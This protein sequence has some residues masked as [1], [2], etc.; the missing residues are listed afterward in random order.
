M[1]AHIGW[2]GVVSHPPSRLLFVIKSLGI[3]GG[4]AE[5]VLSDIV[6]ELA[7]RGHEVT[8][9]SFDPAEGT[10]FYAIGSKVRRLR[11]AV[12]DVRASSGPLDFLRK[13][14]ALRR[15]VRAQE[16]DAAVGFM[17]SAY[18]PLGLAALGTRTR[19][20]A[21]EHTPIDHFGSRPL[22]KLLIRSTASFYSA[23]TAPTDA[24][25]RAYPPGIARK[26]TVI[27]N[28]VTFAPASSGERAP[29]RRRLLTV[30]G[31]RPEK[32]HR[33]LIAA[34][35][36]IANS[37]PEWVLRIVGD[38]PC[39][40]ALERQVSELRLDDRIVFTGAVADVGREYGAADLFVIPSVYESFGLA[41]AEALASGLPVVGFADCP[42]TNILIKHEL[43]GLLV[44][45]EDRVASL[46]GALERLMSSSEQ[47]EAL[48]RAGPASVEQYSLRAVV[49]RWEALLKSVLAT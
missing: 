33:T 27:A 11:L 32:G 41:T 26:I 45:S 13:I 38:G 44:E 34:F 49:D 25:A 6:S 20:I 35:A 48:G 39:R 23:Y 2:R 36:R 17:H 22:Q 19:I 37:R 9:A 46:A 18:V 14:H 40:A 42:G 31:L 7:T 5:R 1:A 21:S 24:V 30:G 8:V 15:L 10:D 29:G 3:E 43:N 12:G 47:R 4:G 28:P 16:P